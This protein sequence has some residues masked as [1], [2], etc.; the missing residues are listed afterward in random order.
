MSAGK[1]LTQEQCNFITQNWHVKCADLAAQMSLEE[2]TI[3]KTKKK[4]GCPK[5]DLRK[6]QLDETFFDAIDNES[7]AY[8]LGFLYAD[9]SI[10]D[11]QGCKLI[12][13][14][15]A[16]SDRNMVEKLKQAISSN[17]PIR[18]YKSQD[19]ISQ[20]ST[21]IIFNSP[22]LFESLIKLGCGRR[23]SLTL[24]F[25]TFEQVPIHLLHH[26]IRGYFDGDGCITFQTVALLKDPSIQ[27]CGTIEFLEALRLHL[28][29]FGMEI[30]TILDKRHKD[31]PT[32]NA[33]S[34]RT[35]SPR[36]IE[37]FY[38]FL[39]KDSTVWMERKR[40]RFDAWF[41]LKPIRDAKSKARRK[42]N[43]S[44]ISEIHHLLSQ[45]HSMRSIGLRFDCSHRMIGEIKT[46]KLYKDCLPNSSV[47][48]ISSGEEHQIG[49]LKAVRS[50]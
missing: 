39:Y 33:F 3:G 43:A 2:S 11:T 20:P 16:Q 49:I 40:N 10:S 1:H 41:A 27:I 7:K 21:E 34:L 30:N 36:M 32:I 6:Y 18:T 47:C 5:R 19:G 9:G 38:D 22:R 46:G 14:A 15:L 50:N 29:T 42:F 4:M 37:R 17:H 24:T 12:K 28:N 44:Q 48:P 31:R 25:P 35:N 26:F 8:W 23:K 45:Q 13:L